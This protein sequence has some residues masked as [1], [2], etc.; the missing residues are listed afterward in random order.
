MSGPAP[1]RVLIVDDE[2][3][4]RRTLRKLVAQD[5]ELAVA[6]E[7]KSGRE[8]VAQLRAA[9]PDLLLLDVQM[10]GMDGFEVLRQ[11][12]V[13][14]PVTIFVTAFDRHAVQAFEAQAL[15]YVLKPFHDERLRRALGRAKAQVRQGR[16]Q[17][18]AQQLA[19][20]L[21]TGAAA[22]AAAL[23]GPRYLERV[24]LRE[25][26]RVQLLGTDEI[27]WIAADDYY[28]EVHAGG[29]A[30][31]LREPLRDLEG[32]LDPARFFRVH[33]SAIVNLSR[34]KEIRSSSQGDHTVLLHDGTE[35]RLSRH[36]RGALFERL[37][38]GPT[39]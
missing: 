33:R 29:Q 22:A 2:P 35:L 4:A 9:P 36:R 10:P 23:P 18:L 25:G 21:G 5:P 6:G 1:L 16:A 26:G 20:L 24:A 38:T 28:A 39:P 19:A 17:G 31:L 27:D 7:C 34:I 14:P 8:A 11:A 3:L 37:G 30:H 12:G 32:R 13:A 15:D